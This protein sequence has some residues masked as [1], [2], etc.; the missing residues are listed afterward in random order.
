M[1]ICTV[2]KRAS[3]GPPC[4]FGVARLVLSTWVPSL[5]FRS[6][7]VVYA[8]GNIP[9]TASKSEKEIL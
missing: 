6:I 3:S 5:A 9:K 7:Q 8:L 4:C 2:I 1:H